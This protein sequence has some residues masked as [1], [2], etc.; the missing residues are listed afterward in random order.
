MQVQKGDTRLQ[1]GING[2]CWLVVWI[3]RTCSCSTRGISSRLLALVSHPREGGGNA[4]GQQESSSPHVWNCK[5]EGTI[6][7]EVAKLS[8]Q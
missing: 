7:L 3:K 8:Q 1:F 6:G 2:D 5:L 4:Q